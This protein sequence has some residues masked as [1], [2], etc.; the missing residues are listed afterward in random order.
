MGGCRLFSA[1]GYQSNSSG[2][3]STKTQIALCRD[4]QFRLN[5]STLVSADVGAVSGSSSSEEQ[6]EGDWQIGRNFEDLRVL[7]LI[8]TDDMEE[9]YVLEGPADALVL[10]GRSFLKTC[11]PAA[12]SCK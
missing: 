8:S 7:R 10:N 6:S 3:Y 9:E 4:G 2:G 5:S 12:V 11:D 1:E